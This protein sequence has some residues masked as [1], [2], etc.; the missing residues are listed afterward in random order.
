MVRMVHGPVMWA[1]F[2]AFRGSSAGTAVAIDGSAEALT[3]SR[4]AWPMVS[5]RFEF[6][7]ALGDETGALIAAFQ[8]I[9]TSPKPQQIRH[10][11]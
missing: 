9:S 11:L 5:L 4:K 1:G 10:D 6:V 2:S 8:P 7:A 3:A